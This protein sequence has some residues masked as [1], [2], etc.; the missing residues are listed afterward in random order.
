MPMIIIMVFAC[1]AYIHSVGSTYEAWTPVFNKT[2]FSSIGIDDVVVSNHAVVKAVAVQHGINN[3]A[4]I[5]LQ[6][7]SD[8]TADVAIPTGDSAFN[9]SIRVE[10]GVIIADRINFTGWESIHICICIGLAILTLLFASVVIKLYRQSWFDY[11]MVAC[12]GGLLFCFFQFLMFSIFLIRGSFLRFSDMAY[13]ICN[14]GSIFVSASLLPMAIM[15]ILVS[16][17]N[18]SLIRHEGKR[19][20]NMLGIAISIVWLIAIFIWLHWWSFGIDHR[21]SLEVVLI[22]DAMVTVAIAFGESLLVSTIICAWAASR[23][24]PKHNADYL[25]ILGCGLRKDGTPSPL[26]AGRVDRALKFDTARTSAGD[27]PATFVP[28]GGQGPDEVMSEAQSMA[29]YILEKG[30]DRGRIV[31][32]DHSTSTRENMSFSRKAIEQHANSDVDNVSVAF[33]TTNY[34]VFRGYVCAHEADMVVEGMGAKT[35][36]YFW[37]NAFL[38]EFAGLLASQWKTILQIYLLI[39]LI[40]ALACYAL[41]VYY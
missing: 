24:I 11:E 28:S 25:V 14:A 20:A 36:S 13:E 5:V 12:G 4:C 23:H 29:Y 27:S 10:D 17:S 8:G 35:R 6:S 32:E 18:I 22:I 21:L 37:P 15:A 40:Y 16:I 9:W 19:P 38:R 41:T 39:A 31:L 7:V 2:D 1:R 30:I 26:L 34:H 3:S 33:S